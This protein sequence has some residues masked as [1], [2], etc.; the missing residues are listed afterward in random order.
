MKP[1]SKSVVTTSL[2]QKIAELADKGFTSGLGSPQPG[3]MCVEA[4]VNYALGADHDDEPECVDGDIRN[5][6]IDLNDNGSYKSNKDRGAALKRVA[7]AQL[8]SNGIDIEKFYRELGNSLLSY[9]ITRLEDEY[10]TK[11]PKGGVKSRLECELRNAEIAEFVRV[12]DG[13]P[14]TKQNK[15]DVEEVLELL[16]GEDD[17]GDRETKVRTDASA[18]RNVLVNQEFDAEKLLDFLTDTK[19][20]KSRNKATRIL[21]DAV[22]NALVACGTEGSKFLYLLD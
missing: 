19:G 9:V 15:L 16:S 21:I 5:I 22:E 13:T 6:K 4:A 2:V 12:L 11:T 8:G 14:V 3:Q 1:K 17:Y 18:V 7:I 20:L 10:T